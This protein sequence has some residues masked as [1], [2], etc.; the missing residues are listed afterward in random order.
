MNTKLIDFVTDKDDDSLC[1]D[2]IDHVESLIQE[3]ADVNAKINGLPCTDLNVFLTFDNLLYHKLKKNCKCEDT[4]LKYACMRHETKLIKTLLKHGATFTDGG[5]SALASAVRFQDME[6]FK[7]FLEK[8]A[9]VNSRDIHNET[10]LRCITKKSY[11]ARRYKDFIEPLLS[12]GANREDFIMTKHK[13]NDKIKIKVILENQGRDEWD[14]YGYDYE[15]P[16]LFKFFN[17]INDPEDFSFDLF[18]HSV[19]V[20]ESGWNVYIF[21]DDDFKKTDSFVGNYNKEEM[22][23]LLEEAQYVFENYYYNGRYYTDDFNME[24][25]IAP[26]ITKLYCETYYFLFVAVCSTREIVIEKL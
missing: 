20:P 17:F 4:L 1:S 19:R 16:E 2:D 11:T 15:D 14:F 5:V 18:Y 7:L 8:G 25:L 12:A 21:T 6:L 22:E 10:L 24:G 9:D 3:G 13:K 26:L 23:K